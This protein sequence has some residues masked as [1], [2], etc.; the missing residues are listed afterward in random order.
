MYNHILI[1]TDGS[2]V[3]QKG[4]DQSLSLARALGARVTILTVT[5]SF[6]VYPAGPPGFSAGLADIVNVAAARQ[7]EEAAK[8]LA[9]AKHGADS[10]GVSAETF[11]VAEAHP[12]EAVIDVAKSRNCDLIAM[13]SHGR[14]GLGRLVLGS[15]TSEVLAH[16]PVPVLVIR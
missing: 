12:A 15:V 5:E 9:A 16:S 11:H 14:R 3:A 2:E 10:L 13:A 8:V 7:K 1:P 4:V 6:P